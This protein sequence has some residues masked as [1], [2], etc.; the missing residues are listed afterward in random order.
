MKN[1]NIYKEYET[2]Y[3]KGDYVTIVKKPYTE[4]NLKLSSDKTEDRIGKLAMKCQYCMNPRCKKACKKDVPIRDINRRLSVGN[5]YGARKLLNKL[6]DTLP[7]REHEV[8]SLRYGLEDGN[9]LTL[10]EVGQIYNLTR[11]RV[12]QIESRAKS[13]LINYSKVN[14]VELVD[15][16]LNQMIAVENADEN[17]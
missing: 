7:Q 14:K 13:K 12:R 2:K 1:C 8:I 5:F 4:E 17:S 11:E 9:E 6:L 15:Q 3:I 16:L 10:E